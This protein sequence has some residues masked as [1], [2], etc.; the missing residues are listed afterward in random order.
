MNV[1]TD[2]ERKL[3]GALGGFMGVTASSPELMDLVMRASELSRE[4]VEATFKGE[5]SDRFNCTMWNLCNDSI[6]AEMISHE[7]ILRKRSSR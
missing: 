2:L 1:T 6:G 7:Q 4:D 3:L 5:A